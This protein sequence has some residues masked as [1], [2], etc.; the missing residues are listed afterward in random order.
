VTVL[1]LA[2]DTSTPV[3]TA[4]VL[5]VMRPHELG[6]ALAAGA[7]DPDPIRVLAERTVTNAF[8]HAEHLMPMVTEVLAETGH[9]T[10]DLEAVVVGIGP[11]PFTGLRVGMVTAAALGDAL[12]I[13]VHGVPSHDAVARAVADRGDFLV[14]TDARRKEV[15]VTA[16]AE[17]REP[18]D[19]PDIVAPAR[20]AEWCAARGRAPQWIAGAGAE[21]AAGLG[22]PVHSPARPLSQGL[23]GCAARAL[24]T[25]AVP[26][27]LTP[28]YLRRPDA[29]EPHAPKPVLPAD[30]PAAGH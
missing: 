28:L 20:L 17:S 30:A 10:K 3:I 4:G 29:S 15:Y 2:I 18:A 26:G 19:G 13:P 5:Q 14:V 23:V 8:G 6:E 25:G 11:G 7:A 12:D 16:Y 1:V 21:L 27:P 9:T 24:L 22:L